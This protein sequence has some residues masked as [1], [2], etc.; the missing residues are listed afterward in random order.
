MN[1][2]VIA[3]PVMPVWMPNTML[4][5]ESMQSPKAL[6]STCSTDIHHSGIDLL[7][8]FMIAL[9]Y[10]GG[11]WRTKAWSWHFDRNSW[12]IV[13]WMVRKSI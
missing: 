5:E 12:M 7:N 2:T 4:A 8:L 6:N 10:W 11:R 1:G 13:E 3:L 9:Q